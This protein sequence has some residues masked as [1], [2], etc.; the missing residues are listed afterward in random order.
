MLFSL[1][2]SEVII[3]II[4]NLFHR[5]ASYKSINKLCMN[6]EHFVR[7]VL[8]KHY[9]KCYIGNR[10]NTNNTQRTSMR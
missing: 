6:S 9:I 3:N 2:Q 1:K 7:A 8:D 5:S 4:W 10:T